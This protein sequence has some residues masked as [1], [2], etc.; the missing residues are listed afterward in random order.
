MVTKLIR[1]NPHNTSNECSKCGYI[2]KENRE[3]QSIFICK[4]CGYTA[5]A[6]FNAS[7]NILHRGITRNV[8]AIKPTIESVEQEAF[9]L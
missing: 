6:D 8:P 9:V 7:L 3:S 1:V 2:N 5:N 4:S